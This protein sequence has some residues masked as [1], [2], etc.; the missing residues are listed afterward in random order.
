[1]NINSMVRQ[2]T[3]IAKTNKKAIQIMPLFVY[4]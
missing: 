1:M 3:P 2:G 4:L